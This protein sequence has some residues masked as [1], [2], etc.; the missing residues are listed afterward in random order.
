MYHPGKGL[1][2]Q[3]SYPKE[4][5]LNLVCIWVQILDPYERNRGVNVDMGPEFGPISTLDQEISPFP[6]TNVRQP[7]QSVESV[8]S[9]HFVYQGSAVRSLFP[10]TNRAAVGREEGLS[11][12]SPPQR[13]ICSSRRSY[14]PAAVLEVCSFR[15]GRQR[16]MGKSAAGLRYF[17]RPGAFS[18]F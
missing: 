17:D 13:P 9:G 4:M 8:F 11:G 7:I 10:G 16:F 12:Q 1:P 15:A 6:N 2:E 14:I 18:A 5:P 3:T